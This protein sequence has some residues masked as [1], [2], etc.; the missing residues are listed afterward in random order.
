V[1]QDH[2]EVSPG[3]PIYPV[4]FGL[5]TALIYGCAL[6][7]ID[8]LV[9][10]RM[11]NDLSLRAL[12][13]LKGSAYSTVL[14]FFA[15]MLPIIFLV[16]PFP[17]PYAHADAAVGP[18]ARKAWVTVVLFYTFVGNFLVAGV[19]QV[20]RSFGAD[21][22]P[23]LLL[24]RYRRPVIEHRIFMFMDLRSS[25]AYAERLGHVKYSSMVRD[26]FQEVNRVLPRFEAEI[27]QYVGDEVV[28][29][30][31]VTEELRPA[32]VLELFFAISD[33]IRARSDKYRERYGLVPEFKA[34][35]HY[36]EV[37]ALEIGGVKRDIAFHGDTVNTAARIQSMCNEYGRTLLVSEDLLALFRGETGSLLVTNPLG[38]VLLR[39][40]TKQVIIHAV[41]RAPKA[42]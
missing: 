3:A 8:A 37:T 31:N 12:I 27:Y 30:W 13:L 33:A 21:L 2:P 40:K 32:R 7:T 34:G 15:A 24:G 6:G 4:V 36:G 18:E 14:L 1:G 41:E 23:S 26:L 16:L 20:S 38:S 35:A 5:A 42:G 39:G 10:R 28:F 17:D 19:K 11:G 9:D 29:T 22:L 25:T